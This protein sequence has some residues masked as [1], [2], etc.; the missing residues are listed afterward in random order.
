M[1]RADGAFEHAAD[2]AGDARGPAQVVNLHRVRQ[3]ADAARL[4]VHVAAALQARSPAR[5]AAGRDAFVEADRR[6]DLRLQ[7]RVI[8]QIVVRQRLLDHRQVELVDL[9]EQRHVV[10]P[11]AAVAVDVETCA[12]GML[13]ADGPQHRQVPAGTELELDPRKA[14]L[15]RLAD[16]GQQVVDRV[17]DA[18]VGPDGDFVAVR[19]AGSSPAACAAACR[20]AATAGPTRR[21]RGPPWRTGFP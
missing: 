13:P 3:P 14:L 9:A 19:T 5:L 16:R 10:E 8:D 4:D 11:I 2:P 7:R 1:A 18:E 21:C 15:D 6:A 17:H 20:I 12:A